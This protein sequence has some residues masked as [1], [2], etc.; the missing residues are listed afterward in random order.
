[1]TA[2]G[3]HAVDVV[4]GSIAVVIDHVA[5]FGCWQ[6]GP[7][8]R[9]DSTRLAL[10]HAELASPRVHHRAARRLQPHDVVVDR[11][12]T[13]VVDVV[14]RLGA[15]FLGPDTRRHA[16]HAL[17]GAF[18]ARENVARAA[19]HADIRG[20]VV[21][22]AITVVIEIVAS[23]GDL[24]WFFDVW[25]DALP[26]GIH[27]GIFA[28]VRDEPTNAAVKR[29]VATTE[30]IELRITREVILVVDQA[31]AIIVQTVTRFDAQVCRGAVVFTPSRC[32]TIEI[33]P[34]RL[35]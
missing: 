1:M 25:P 11:A 2:G 6:N 10:L 8:A 26:L 22:R 29:F 19:R 7:D 15:G 13:V 30:R 18:L 4:D 16:V 27:A 34:A 12:V 35:A 21:G 33:V 9:D 23:L 32:R 31:V 5:C 28:G 17:H 3:A 24:S 14:A 20:V